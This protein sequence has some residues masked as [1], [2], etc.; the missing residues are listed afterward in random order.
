MTIKLA[1]RVL[2]VTA[3]TGT[4]SVTIG[5]PV[6]GYQGFVAGGIANSDEVRYLITEGNA[7]EIGTGVYNAGVLSRVA[8][9]SSIGGGEITLLGNA[10]VAIAATASDFTGVQPGDLATVATT[11]AYADLSGKPTLGTAAA[12]NVGTGAAQVV[13]LDG[14]ARLPAVDGS[15]LTG[16]PSGDVAGPASAVNNGVALFNGTTGKLLKDGGTLAAVALSGDYDDLTDKPTLGTAAALNVGT[17]ALNVVQLDGSAK[18]PAVDGSQLTNLPTPSG[19]GDVVGPASATNNAVPQYDGTTGKLLKNGPS[20]GTAANNLVQL[21]GSAKLPAV[22]GSQ[23]TNIA[24]A[25]GVGDVVGPASATNN[26]LA[27]FDG[28][29]GKL[30]KDGPAA[31]TGAIVGTTD[32]QTLSGKTIERA[33]LNDGYTEEVFAIT[34]GATVNLAPNNGSIQTWTLGASR[35]PGQANWSAG[36]TITLLVDDG[37]AYTITWSTLAVVWKTDGGVA[38]TLETTGVTV[39]VLWKVGTTI[40]GARVGDK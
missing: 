18:L 19:V 37:T 36:Q 32:T 9:E 38:P 26:A 24:A 4:G 31:P 16:L 11:G 13:Q 33:V 14:L 7:W 15:Q 8:S 6:A 25:T 34:D 5:S 22:D 39:I 21:D 10:R 17:A 23:L 28:T 40:Y 12:L 3:T 30:L 29:T 2:T 1:N 20:I 35:T 27:Q